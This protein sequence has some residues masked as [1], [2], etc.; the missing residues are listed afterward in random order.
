[1]SELRLY[2]D[3][4]LQQVNKIKENDELGDAPEVRVKF[5]L[6]V[7][8]VINN[9]LDMNVCLFSGR[10]GHRKYGEVYMHHFPKNSRRM[11]ADSKSYFRHRYGNT[12]STRISSSSSNQ[13]PKGTL[14][15]AVVIALK[16]KYMCIVLTSFF[17][18]RLNL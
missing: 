2:C 6:D 15:L 4:L 8:S 11:H 9:I 18:S 13:T 1:M 7:I 14:L 3:L 5:G 16:Y 10:H 12:Q 17:S